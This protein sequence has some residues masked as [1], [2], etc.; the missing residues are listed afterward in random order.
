MEACA[1]ELGAYRGMGMADL[2]EFN[3]EVDMVNHHEYQM[4][5]QSERGFR[6][7]QRLLSIVCCMSLRLLQLS[8]SSQY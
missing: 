6:H 2:E 4:V 1:L 8:E 3:P 7:Y 5:A